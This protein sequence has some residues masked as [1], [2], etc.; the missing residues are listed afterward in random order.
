MLRTGHIALALDGT[1]EVDRDLALAA[2]ASQ[3]P[4]TRMLVTSQALPRILTGDP[5]WEVRELPADIGNLRDGLLELWLGKEKGAVL[6]RRIVAEGLSAITLSGYDLRLL[7]DLATSDPERAD[8]PGDRVTL[9]RTM[10]ARAI[11]PDGQP[12]A[13][14]G[15]MQLAWTM[16]TQRR[17]RIAA[18]DANLLDTDAV[19]ALSAEGVRIIR[20]I[21]ADYE[22]RHDQMRAFLASLW[23]VEETPT[24]A[25]LQKTAKDSGAFDIS[26]RDQEELWRFVAPLLTSSGDLSAMWNFAS[27]EPEERVHLLSALQ[28]EAAKR[29][30]TLVR[31][32]HQ[33]DLETVG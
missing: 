16:M 32:A 14:Q 18:G 28:A 24:L 20:P 31:V 30:V 12:L 25:A 22:F 29:N 13:L 8:L 4:K 15:L 23:L 2:F 21:G 3:F 6:G 7:A 10:L 9:Y 1:N 11:G 26:R 27:D 17:R 33:R 5:H 19:R